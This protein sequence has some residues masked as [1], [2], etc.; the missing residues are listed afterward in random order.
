MAVSS[1]RRTII[2]WWGLFL[3]MQVIERLFL[4]PETI[5]MEAPTAGLFAKVLAVS[6]RAD[7][8]VATMAVGV[9]LAIA[10]I[11]GW[12][13][14][15]QPL[16]P[17]AR[18]RNIYRSIFMKTAFTIACALL[19][20]LTADMA[21]YLYNHRHLDYVFFEYFTDLVNVRQSQTSQASS[22]TQ[23]ELS[24]I[25][26]W[27]GRV[28]IFIS[29][30]AAAVL[31]WIVMF[32]KALGPALSKL[33]ARI[34]SQANVLLALGLIVGG[35]G[36]DTYG[37]W[38]VQR[39]GINSS[40][41]Y[42]FA[43][44]PIWLVVEVYHSTF[45]YELHGGGTDGMLKRVPLDDA[46]RTSQQTLGAG[47]VFP[48]PKY[49]FVHPLTRPGKVPLKRPPN[50]LVILIEGLDRRFLNR[51]IS[52]A[53]AAE[54]KAAAGISVT[55][56]MDRLKTDS[57]Y[58]ENF[59]ANSTQTFHGMAVTLCSDAP[60]FGQSSIQALFTHDYLC[61]PS[62]LKKAG[63]RTEMVTGMNRDDRQ[64]HNALFMARNGVDRLFDENDFPAQAKR[65]GLG[66]TDGDLFDMIQSRLRIL[67][68][69]KQPFFLA[70]ITASTHH[71]YHIP[72]SHP[73]VKALADQKDQ[74]I[75][76]LRYV[77]AELERMFENLRSEHLLDNTVVF[78]LGDHG[79][80]EEI[81][82]DVPEQLI[83]HF[84]SPLFVWVDH[85]LRTPLRYRP[86]SVS[87]VAS[88]ADLTPTILGLTG[89]MPR[90][91]PFLGR[92]ISCLLASDCLAENTAFLSSVRHNMIGWVDRTSIMLYSVAQDRLLYEMDLDVLKVFRDRNSNVADYADKLHLLLSYFV[93][94]N[95]VRERNQVWSWKELGQELE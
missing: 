23:A 71:P 57:V 93:S 36:L 27:A 31:A 86:R 14:S 48:Y 65:V 41:Y 78:I 9:C 38:A 73:E 53:T 82:P 37:P 5:A 70:T 50:I 21:Y 42:G 16:W 39:S 24:Q 8:T 87:T 91:A 3:V 6:I 77:D 84:M 74:Y 46:V 90:I 28:I 2:F 35:T 67:S 30:E 55:P 95:V 56:F 17:G 68:R 75:P 29:L 47:T 33:R 60:R 94:T 64:A 34:P 40:V 58:F 61:L 81:G 32:K 26:K 52:P 44:N 12:L 59:F 11:G 66:K 1:F 62:I 92:D 63:Y 13:L 88:Q 43:Q 79:R 25:G 45:H 51:T 4:I 83:G 49:P 20:L 89:L 7:L 18:N 72:L 80:H 10:G 19:M 69:Q 22:Q 15:K 54:V 76:A 85:S